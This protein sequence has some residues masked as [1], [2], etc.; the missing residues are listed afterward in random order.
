MGGISCGMWKAKH[1]T[2]HV[3]TNDTAHD[4]DIQFIPFIATSTKFFEGVYSSFYEQKIPFGSFAKTMVR[5]QHILGYLYI[6]L[7][8]I[9][10][11][12]ISPTFIVF[13]PRFLNGTLKEL[14]LMA[15]YY[16]W[17]FYFLSFLPSWKHG[18]VYFLVNNI[19]TSIVFAQ[20]VMA[21]LAMPTPE[22]SNDMEFFRH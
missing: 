6:P 4:P 5:I 14:F 13:S 12:L 7:F 2:H 21:H 3:V 1:L 20:I 15:V 9:V 8:K 16:I 19:V 10:W 17:F 22:I 18:L 11:H